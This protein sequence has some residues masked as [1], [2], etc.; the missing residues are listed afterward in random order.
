[1]YSL[2]KSLSKK[3]ENLPLLPG[4]YLYKNSEDKIIYVGKAIKL[5]NR[6]KSYFANFDRLDPKTRVLIKN[7]ADL[8][9]L[10]CDSEAEALILETNLIKKFRP[11]YNR[12][13]IDDKNYSWIM[14]NYSEDFPKIKLVRDKKVLNSKTKYFGPYP[15]TFPAKDVLKRLRRL[16]HYRSCNRAMY[17]ENNKVICSDKKPCLYYHLGLC[18]APCASKILKLEYRKSIKNIEKFLNGEKSKIVQEIETEMKTSAKLQDFENAAMQRDK[19]INIKYVLNKVNFAD[20]IDDIYILNQKESERL[21]AQKELFEILGIWKESFTNE[22]MKIE[23][24]DISNIQGTNPVGSMVVVVNGVPRNDLYRKFKIKS[25]NSPDDFSMHQEMMERRILNY[26]SENDDL[27]F[28]TLPNLMIIDGGKGQLS[29]VYEILCK[30]KLENKINLCALAKKDEELFIVDKEQGGFIK[31]KIPKRRESL[32]LVQR[33]RDE[34]HRFGI[35]FH[36]K[37][38]SKQMLS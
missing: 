30:Y 22:E 15:S 7:I 17:Q 38:R 26:L 21:N 4:C 9:F 32:K 12:L 18:D 34:S 5:R 14:I 23:C 25:K 24:F 36:R 11:K 3:I 10:V 35:T 6:V 27:S 1:M 20:E 13:M 2:S 19:L 29:S 33:I 8:D 16:F 37:L 28:S 31:I